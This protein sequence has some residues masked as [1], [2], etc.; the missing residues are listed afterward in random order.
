MLKLDEN[1][2]CVFLRFLVC[3]FI[4]HV[5]SCY[6]EETVLPQVSK[7]RE[8]QRQAW[9]YWDLIPSYSQSSFENSKQKWVVSDFQTCLRD[10]S[11]FDSTFSKLFKT[12]KKQKKHRWA[13]LGYS[14]LKFSCSHGTLEWQM[15]RQRR[16]PAPP[17]GV[18]STKAVGWIQLNNVLYWKISDI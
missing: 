14:W 5:N 3:E 9:K 15:I 16:H 1:G 7:T 6:W 13:W 11:R 18:K 4:C 17:L 12:A 10:D 8:K 2:P